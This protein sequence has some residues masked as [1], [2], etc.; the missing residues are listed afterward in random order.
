MK[1]I[2]FI[3]GDLRMLFAARAF[4]AHGFCVTALGFDLAPAEF[5]DIEKAEGAAALAGVDFAVLAPPVSRDGENIYAPFSAARIPLRGLDF[6]GAAVFSGGACPQIAAEMRSY[7]AREAF[8]VRNAVLTAEGALK[9]AMEAT[10]RSICG[11]RACVLGFGRIGAALARDLRALG[12]E[13]DVFA[14]RSESRALAWGLGARAYPFDALG[15][16][17]GS[18]GCIFNTVPQRVAGESELRAISAGAPFIELAS[19]PGGAEPALARSLGVNYIHAGG[20]PGK[21]MPASAGEIV[22]ETVKEMME[23]T[24]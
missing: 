5:C 18:Y 9:L 24:I 14:R 19:A 16:N 6:G 13:V 21:I 8:A 15:A 4:A 20:L 23:E 3:G 12:A 11:M 22:Y 1:K 2:A 7:A 10:G 17:I